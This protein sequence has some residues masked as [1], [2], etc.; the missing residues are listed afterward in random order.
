MEVSISTLRVLCGGHVP[1]YMQ[2]Y[3]FGRHWATGIE[4]MVGVVV[5]CSG[6]HIWLFMEVSTAVLSCT[7][8]VFSGHAT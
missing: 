7:Q 3:F 5:M 2:R 8:Q 4:H 6:Q 1:E